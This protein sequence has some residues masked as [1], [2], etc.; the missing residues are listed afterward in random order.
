MSDSDSESNHSNSN[1]SDDD[2]DSEFSIPDIESIGD[3][4]N[5]S[6]EIDEETH[7]YYY[8]YPRSIENP[9]FG[10]SIEGPVD[11][12]IIL[13]M[14]LDGSF[15]LLTYEIRQKRFCEWQLIDEPNNFPKSY[16]IEAER[17]HTENTSLREIFLKF[18]FDGSAT[19][20]RDEMIHLMDA[21]QFP[22][23]LHEKEFLEIAGDDAEIDFLE[24]H[25]Y[26]RR[27]APNIIDE[28]M[29]YY[30][31]EEGEIEGPTPQLCVRFWIDS[32]YFKYETK[33]RHEEYDNF[34]RLG[35]N[36]KKFP[37][38]WINRANAGE[39]DNVAKLKEK[40]RLKKLNRI[41]VHEKY[42]ALPKVELFSKYVEQKIYD[43]ED[44]RRLRK[45]L[46]LKYDP[47]SELFNPNVRILKDHLYDK[48]RYQLYETLIFFNNVMSNGKKDLIHVINENMEKKKKL[49][50]KNGTVLTEYSNEGNINMLY[51]N[52]LNDELINDIM[53][54]IDPTEF[55]TTNS[56]YTF[57]RACTEE[58]IVISLLHKDID[59]YIEKIN[60]DITNHREYVS[61][62]RSM[63]ASVKMDTDSNTGK[64]TGKSGTKDTSRRTK[65][66]R[67]V[68]IEFSIA[69]AGSL[70]CLYNYD[71]LRE[72][73]D[74]RIE[75]DLP[76]KT[77]KYVPEKCWVIMAT[78]TECPV[79]FDKWIYII[80]L[81]T[82]GNNNEKHHGGNGDGGER[83]QI[84]DDLN[85]EVKM[86]LKWNQW[87]P[88]GSKEM[89]HF[90]RCVAQCPLRKYSEK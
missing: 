81:N 11:V 10:Y 64:S 29:W 51:E 32:G 26:L 76:V 87:M 52:R 15:D 2:S 24:F 75:F 78:L 34:L 17:R 84:E 85:E 53:R 50:K 47:L 13:Q 33:V 42:S 65:R 43:T 38:D 58:Q 27:V 21:L 66:T 22:T 72:E 88:A 30:I 7:K 19:I 49:R 39:L 77:H 60:I 1:D 12:D 3:E 83:Q 63:E 45:K 86:Q 37:D 55:L 48:L 62:K 40:E 35:E 57:G 16:I 14:L 6:K 54:L 79:P 4:S 25:E 71:R 28:P 89:Y 36:M 90:L 18:D 5:F 74:K 73:E 70:P 59:T 61:T 41:W 80:S 23:P 56:M 8:R 46:P 67:S 9:H 20:D 69:G 82:K 44:A 31:D 68:G